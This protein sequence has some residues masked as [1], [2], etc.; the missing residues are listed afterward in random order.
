MI[1]SRLQKNCIKYLK[2]EGIYH[3]NIHGGG[4]GAKG[5]PDIIACING[6]FVAFELKTGDNDMQPDQRIHRKRIVTN[7]GRHY[8]PRSLQEFISIVREVQ[9]TTNYNKKT[10]IEKGGN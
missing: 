4:W 9:D 5:A 2:S 7:G 3:V 1:E 8:C 6:K 10:D